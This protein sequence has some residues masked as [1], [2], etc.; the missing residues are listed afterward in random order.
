MNNSCV[1]FCLSMGGGGTI[2]TNKFGQYTTILNI[3]MIFLWSSLAG[4]TSSL[5]SSNTSQQVWVYA[6]NFFNRTRA[7]SS[8]IYNCNSPTNHL[9]HSSSWLSPPA[10]L[11]I[12]AACKDCPSKWRA[13]ETSH[14]TPV[15]AV[16]RLCILEETVACSGW[17]RMRWV[18]C[19]WSV[20][21]F[22]VLCDINIYVLMMYGILI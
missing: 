11:N 20:V 14:S 1:K 3:N 5:M 21:H 10:P 17:I 8:S 7:T 16:M 15:S 18:S 12:Y 22:L 13:L 2:Q 6:H 4:A 9:P 19:F